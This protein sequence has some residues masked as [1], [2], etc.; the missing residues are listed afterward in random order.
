M[1]S[2]RVIFGVSHGTVC[3][4]MDEVAQLIVDK[5]HLPCGAARS[6]PALHVAHLTKPRATGS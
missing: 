6:T 5:L 1:R 4:L 3:T 2:T